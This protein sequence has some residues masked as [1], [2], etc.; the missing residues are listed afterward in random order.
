MP[1]IGLAA[2]SFGKMG[3]LLV[4]TFLTNVKTFNRPVVAHD[5]GID[6]ALGPEFRMLLYNRVKHSFHVEGFYGFV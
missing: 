5:A 2:T 3:S 6:Q 1:K 4:F